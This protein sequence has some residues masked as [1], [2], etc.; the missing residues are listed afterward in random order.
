MP[1]TSLPIILYL[2][3]LAEFCW[4]LLLCSWSNF[5]KICVDPML[6]NRY[7]IMENAYI[8]GKM[9]VKLEKCIKEII[10][11]NTM[12]SF[13]F[14]VIFRISKRFL[15]PYQIANVYD[16]WQLVISHIIFWLS[17]Y[18]ILAVPYVL[19]AR[20]LSISTLFQ[21]S[22]GSIAC[23]AWKG[24]TLVLGDV[25]GNLNF[26]D[27]KARL[28]RYKCILLKTRQVKCVPMHVCVQDD[29]IPK[30]RKLLHTTAS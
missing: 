17:D 27:L 5:H 7:P 28:S 1:R 22:M 4:K 19:C 12:V 24:D 14:S 21:G 15:A 8:S 13:S 10:F 26:W 29:L 20:N 3:E 16:N 25:D 18:D 23:I 30:L 9:S 11:R 2:A 6:L